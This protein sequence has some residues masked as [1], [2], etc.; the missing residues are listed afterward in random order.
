MERVEY[1]NTSREGDD[2][3]LYDIL[4]AEILGPVSHY[5]KKDNGRPR[6]STLDS[7]AQALVWNK[8]VKFTEGELGTEKSIGDS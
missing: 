1:I 2:S 6:Q 7:D 5:S 3:Q 4:H 8:S